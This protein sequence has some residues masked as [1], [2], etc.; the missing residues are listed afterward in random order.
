[1][2]NF[3]PIEGEEDNDGSVEAVGNDGDLGGL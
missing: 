1:M 2:P 3:V